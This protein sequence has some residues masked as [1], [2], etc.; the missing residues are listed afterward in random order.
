[1]ETFTI[2][3]NLGKNNPSFLFISLSALFSQYV[4]IIT[5]NNFK[6]EANYIYLLDSF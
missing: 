3:V 2:V 6:R 5:T 1:M 4:F